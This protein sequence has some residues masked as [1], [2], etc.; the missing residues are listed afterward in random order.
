MTVNRWPEKWAPAFAT[1]CPLWQGKKSP[2][3]ALQKPRWSRHR[4][5]GGSQPHWLRRNARTVSQLWAAFL[6]VS[7]FAVPSVAFAQAKSPNRPTVPVQSVKAQV[8]K[9]RPQDDQRVF[10]IKHADVEVIA[11]TLQIFGVRIQPN[12]DLRVIGVSAPPALMPAIEDAIR[13]FDVPSPPPKNV[14]LTA[15]LM[16]A[17][18]RE[19][20]AGPLP[21]ELDP[22]VKQLKANFVL[23]AFRLL[24]TLVVRSR[25]R[26][27]GKVTGVARANPQDRQPLEYD[28]AYESA[29]VQP[30]EPPR[31]IRLDGLKLYGKIAVEGYS[32]GFAGF[33]AAIDVR[34]GQKVVVGKTAAGETNSALIVVISAKVLD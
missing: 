19:A 30:G 20:D 7:V 3:I 10:V 21:T 12:R 32:P 26:T 17:S 6:W 13:R 24:D 1:I 2:T 23:K 25:D 8:S 16:I 22:V 28:F 9:E 15:Y 4:R 11:R 31:S 33:S 29:T 18:D 5:P 34:E 27:G 14:E